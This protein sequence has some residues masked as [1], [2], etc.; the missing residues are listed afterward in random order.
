MSRIGKLDAP[1]NPEKG[2]VEKDTKT[3]KSLE[4]NRAKLERPAAN[5]N[6]FSKEIPKGNE[7]VSPPAKRKIAGFENRPNKRY[8]MDSPKT[9]Q[10]IGRKMDPESQKFYKKALQSGENP[11]IKLIPKD[12]EF[13]KTGDKSSGNFLT[14]KHPGKNALERKENLQLP[15]ENDGKFVSKVKSKRPQLG[16]ESDIVPQPEWAKQAGYTAR[17]GMKQIYTP[18]TNPEGAISDG[19]YELKVKK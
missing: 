12:A 17:P 3:P 6:R 7:P 13:Y 5:Q 8:D 10:E 4:E 18:N 16:I 9:I 15:P 14:E 2:I 19:R 1:H 11:K